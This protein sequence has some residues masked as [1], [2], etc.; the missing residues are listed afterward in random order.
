MKHIG[1]LLLIIMEIV[2]CGMLGSALS[3]VFG[4][5]RWPVFITVCLFLCEICCRINKQIY[6]RHE[7]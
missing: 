4:M 7:K 1:V 2:I 6:P 3:S 5:L